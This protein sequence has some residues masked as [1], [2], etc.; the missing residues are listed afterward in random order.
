VHHDQTAAD[1]TVAP[2][3]AGASALTADAY[4]LRRLPVG[5]ALQ[6]LISALIGVEVKVPG[7]IPLA[8]AP[9][10]AMV[11]SVQFS[12]GD[13]P[14]GLKGEAGVNTRLTGIRN[15]AGH[16]HGA[17]NCTTLLALLTPIGVVRLLE[18]RPLGQA[19]RLLAKV[20]ELLDHR[21]TCTLERE[22]A[23]TPDLEDRLRSFA[24]WLES[25][26][27][28]ARQ[29]DRGALRA[30][31]AATRLCREP[32]ADVERLAAEQQVSRRQLERDFARWV[33]TSPRH[34]TQVARLQR[35]SRRACRGASLADIAADVGFA[36]QAHMS[37]VVRALTGLTPR[38]FIRSESSPLKEAFREATGGNT[39]YL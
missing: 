36:D 9:H 3:L 7:P 26:A 35:V 39:V 21:L 31:R 28:N 38:Q 16:F 34:L 24:H 2:T 27:L 4:R 15:H 22:L 10:E 32:A 12:H 20:A 17:G 30:G 13:D 11:L 37:R 14:I 8:V 5:G 18:G 1:I 19:P 23:T 6:G 33:G 25:R 29:V